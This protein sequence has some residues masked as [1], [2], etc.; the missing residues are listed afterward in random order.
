M[1]AAHLLI[2]LPFRD[3][4][5]ILGAVISI[6]PTI[7]PKLRT[8]NRAIGATTIAQEGKLIALTFQLVEHF[9]DSLEKPSLTLR[10]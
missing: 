4:V 7:E 8:M 9:W 3:V 2:N 10:G 6:E 5:E 1:T